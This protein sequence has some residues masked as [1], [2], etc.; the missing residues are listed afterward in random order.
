MLRLPGIGPK[1]VK[2]LHEELSI[3]T[4]EQLKAACDA[5]TVAALKG[6]G[7]K[8]LD[9]ILEGILKKRKSRPQTG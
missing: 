8:T 2:A 9:K 4:I 6:F 1:K 3:D 7:K 5:G